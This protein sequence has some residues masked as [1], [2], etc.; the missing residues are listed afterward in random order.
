MSQPADRK[1]PKSRAKTAYGLLTELEHV[2]ARE[3]K[4]L[5]M[6][7]VLL[8]GE[9]ITDA[10]PHLMFPRQTPSCGTVGC[11]AGWTITLRSPLDTLQNVRITCDTS[12]ARKI[13]GLTFEQNHELFFDVELVNDGTA[14][15]QTR[16]HADAVIA[17]IRRF[18]A[19]YAKQLRSHKLPPIA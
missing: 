3:P 15:R 17:H 6:S 18:K 7:I 14:H 8:R 9:A 4:R 10:N 5:D 19:E 11:I 1:I 12:T 16:E 13:L 2:I